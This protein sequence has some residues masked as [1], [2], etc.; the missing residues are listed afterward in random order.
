MRTV[1]AGLVVCAV[2][3]GCVARPEWQGPLP[4]RNQH[5]AQLT[6]MHMA[7]ASA[8]V[9]AAGKASARL[10][11]AYSS[12]FLD[13]ASPDANFFMD[14]EYLRAAAGV[15]VG[16]GHGIELGTELPFA[17]TS[18]G[19]LDSFIIDYHDAFGLPDQNRKE[20]PRDQ[21]DIV[22]TQGP[23]EVFRVEQDGFEL[24][25]VPVQVGVEI[26]EPALERVGV[27]VRGGIELPTGDDERGYGSGG[28]DAG[29]GIVLEYRMA[30]IAWYGHA[31][32]TFA[33]TPDPASRAG[34]HFEDVTSAGLGLEVPFA[35]DLHGF[36][37][38][39]WEN[40]ALRELDLQVTQRDHVLL[41]AGARWR[42][43]KHLGLEFGLGEDLQTLVSPDFTAWLGV[44]WQ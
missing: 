10:D 38:V 32:H 33:G 14:G 13:D 31:Q 40:S 18:G 26:V 35:S 11:A 39:E 42:T 21:F 19:F 28:L 15:R 16:L 17:H 2:A 30:T 29:A 34:F 12:L 37:Q 20:Y 6:V 44:I 1:L 24:L 43:T 3:G 5:P 7:P 27:Q 41:W 23:N 25:D 22:A 4:V 9:L 8:A 36:V